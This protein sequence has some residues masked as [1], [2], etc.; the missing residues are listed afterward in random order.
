[1]WETKKDLY[2]SIISELLHNSHVEIHI[3]HLSDEI[4][5]NETVLRLSGLLD[6]IA[7]ILR[8]DSL[9]DFYCV[10]SIVCLLEDHDISCGVRHDFR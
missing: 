5:Q 8:D 10:E 2:Q 7:E 6:K 3:S 4:L 9:D 1:M